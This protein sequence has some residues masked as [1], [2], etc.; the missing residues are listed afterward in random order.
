MTPS[1]VTHSALGYNRRSICG[2][3]PSCMEYPIGFFLQLFQPPTLAWHRYCVCIL[4]VYR[5]W[6]KLGHGM[7][8]WA[9]SLLLHTHPILARLVVARSLVTL[10]LQHI[11]GSSIVHSNGTMHIST[12]WLEIDLQLAQ[13]TLLVDVDI[14][15][16]IEILWM[17]DVYIS[18]FIL[19]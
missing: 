3:V 5:Y 12:W 1:V 10:Y 4:M 2:I 7:Y 17:M 15:S 19:V 16:Y 11:R 13:L 6:L 18:I 8:Q 14:I 9:R